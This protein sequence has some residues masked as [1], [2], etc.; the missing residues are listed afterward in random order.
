MLTMVEDLSEKSCPE[1][2]YVAQ[3]S[4]RCRVFTPRALGMG[5]LSGHPRDVIAAEI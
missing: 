2:A 5:G 4:L 3:F 1:R